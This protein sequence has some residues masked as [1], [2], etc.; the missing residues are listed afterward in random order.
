MIRRNTWIILALLVALLGFTF[1]FNN[2]KALTAMENTPAPE[3][4][5]VFT[6]EEGQ[7]ASIR[8]VASTGEIV[9]LAHDEQGK[10]VLK[11]PIAAAADQGLAESAASQVST[12]RVLDEVDL[13]PAM[14]GLDH[15]AYTFTIRFTSGKVHKLDIGSLTPTQSGYYVRVDGKTTKIVSGSGIDALLGLLTFPPYLVTPTPSP[16]PASETP[17]PVTEAAPSPTP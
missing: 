10:W 1:Y 16:L 9:E 2:R 8:I 7:P 4:A 12:L 5:F 13:E 3:T 11:A 14:I 15:P 6:A 17:G